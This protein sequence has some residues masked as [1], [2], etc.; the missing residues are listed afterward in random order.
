[1]QLQDAARQVVASLGA[2]D[3]LHLA[4]FSSDV[5]SP[6]DGLRVMDAAA[7]ADAIDAIDATFAG[8]GTNIVAGLERAYDALGSADLERTPLV[9]LL[10]D[11]QAQV[12]GATRQRVVERASEGVRL[13]TLAF[14][15]D[16]DWPL[17]Y[18]LAE[19]G[20]GVA[21][22]IETGVGAEADIQRFMEA[23][24]TPVLRDLRIEYD[25]GIEAQVQAVDILFSGSEL[26]VVGTFDP[27]LDAISGTVHAESADGPVEAPFSIPVDAAADHPFLQRLVVS[28]RIRDLEDRLA[29]GDTTAEAPL[30]ALALEH[31]FVTDLTSLVLLLPESGMAQERQATAGLAQD[32]AATGMA[33]SG[34]SFSTTRASSATSASWSASS[35][36][37]SADE[38]SAK[39]TPGPGIPGAA[40]ALALA[41]LVRRCS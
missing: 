40:A 8:G 18:G 31:S 3:R 34:T 12:D 15:A 21:E 30:K 36:G 22:H 1:V 38:E 4:F 10:S 35:T 14:G 28:Q 27:T 16:A 25:A 6:W 39:S 5:R 41:F 26:I 17:L 2:E 13:F 23:W 20:Q 37:V 9:M 11:G 7:R 29:A 24:T 19:E 32:A 33:A